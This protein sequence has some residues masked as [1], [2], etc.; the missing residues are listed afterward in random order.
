[1]PSRVCYFVLAVAPL[2]LSTPGSAITIPTGTIIDLRLTTEVSSDK[3]SGTPVS[4]VVISPVE[5]NNTLVIGFKT[6]LDGVTADS[7]ANQPAA[8]GSEEKPAT[9]RVNLTKIHDGGQSKAISCTLVGVDNAR[10]SVDQSGLITGIKASQTFSSLADSGVNKVTEKNAQLGQLLSGIKKSFAKEADPSIDYK[11]GIEFTIKLTQP[12]DWNPTSQKLPPPITPAAQLNA[13]VAQEPF[14]TVALKPPSPSDLTNLMFIGTEN[15]IKNAFKESGWFAS[16][17]LGRS[18]TMK[19]AS[20]IIQNDGYDEAPMSVLTLNNKPP[21]MT[22]E[23][24]NNTFASRHHIRLFLMPQQFAGKPVYVAAATHDIKIYFSK[25]SRSIT[26]GIDPNIDN[27]RSKVTND[28]LFT[29]TVAGVSLVDRA[30]IPKDISNAT[31][32]RLQTDD[33]VSVIEFK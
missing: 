12:L 2:T 11:P 15:Q 14:R 18:S 16:D 32:D 30:N 28:V 24:Q 10:E 5:V 17:P 3:P 4:A 13:L 25:T 19:T 7:N 6:Q 31:G 21:D 1:M 8:N 33:K 26:H 29:G 9:L 23:K 20:A 27:E 22:F